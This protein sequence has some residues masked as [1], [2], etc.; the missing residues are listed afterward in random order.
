V[1]QRL[2][3]VNLAKINLLRFAH[4]YFHNNLITVKDNDIAPVLGDALNLKV[5][6]NAS[7]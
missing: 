5:H 2:L 1:Q 6:Q 7:L 3:T 4:K